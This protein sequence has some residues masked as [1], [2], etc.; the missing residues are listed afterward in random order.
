MD[1]MLLGF[2]Y[3]SLVLCN[4]DKQ[5]T[6]ML[7]IQGD[8]TSHL[9]KQASSIEQA[10]DSLSAAVKELRKSGMSAESPLVMCLVQRHIETCEQVMGELGAITA[11][12]SAVAHQLRASTLALIVALS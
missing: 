9:K 5:I 10:R 12:C 4:V 1:S 11:T 7:E 8:K 2:T 3:S 6:K